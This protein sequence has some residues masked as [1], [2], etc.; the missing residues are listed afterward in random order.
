MRNEL[1]IACGAGLLLGACGGET[2]ERP[3][4]PPV[5]WRSFEV[6]GVPDAGARGP[7]A[8]ERAVGEAYTAALGAPGFAPLGPQLDDDVHFAFPGLEDAHGREAVM[9]SHD[10]LFGSFDSRRVAMT[11]AWRTDSAQCVEWTMTGLQ[12]RSWMGVIASQKPVTFKGLT[13]LWTRDDGAITDVHVYFDVA[14]VKAQL[15]V[16][17]KELLALPAPPVPSG[18][19]QTYEQAG[20]AGEKAGV[21][22][23]AASLDALE[24]NSEGVF[25][26]ARTDDFEAYTLERAVPAHGKD[27]ARAYFKAMHKAIGQLDTTID[28]A[29][30]V[31]QFAVV[32]YSIAGEQLGPI[33]WLP[34]Q[35]DKV[36][37]LHV[38]DVNELHDGRIARTWRYDNPAELLPP[39]AR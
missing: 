23:V 28:N 30:G 37:R 1:T 7:T 29:W 31:G 21:D 22:V 13:L 26:D 14:L 6:R 2:V 39:A 4:P 16:G 24:K 10:A 36:V 15:G 25:V 3:P 32:E 35:R 34:A 20:T 12:T 33:G 5:D 18:A 27:E 8:R 9:R 11:R 19:P 38:V 17:P